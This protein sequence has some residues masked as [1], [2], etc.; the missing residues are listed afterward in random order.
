MLAPVARWQGLRVVAG[1]AT[2]RMS[3]LRACLRMRTAWL[4][5]ISA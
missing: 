5:L 1:D 4:R 3:V 2:A